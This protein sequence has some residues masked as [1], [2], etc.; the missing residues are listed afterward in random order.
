MDHFVDIDFKPDP[1]FS[2][3]IL[4]EALFAKFH[5]ALVTIRPGGIGVSFPKSIENNLG[6]RFR[7]H[8]DKE[9]LSRFMEQSWYQI[10]R[11]YIEVSP[12]QNIPRDCKYR[13]VRR[14]QAKTSN[15]RFSRRMAQK[16]ILEMEEAQ[17][18]LVNRKVPMLE[19]PFIWL[20][21]AST[22]Q[23]FPLHILQGELHDHPR[24]GEFSAYGLS[25]SATV[26]W[27]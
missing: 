19:L 24:A 22:G 25:S 26:P 16:G 7:I 17:Q 11:D 6:D 4:L 10:L 3:R 21:S 5:R 13:I 14:V 9:S 1:E 18:R 12:I 15:E 2:E 23:K 20:R 27:F 8:G